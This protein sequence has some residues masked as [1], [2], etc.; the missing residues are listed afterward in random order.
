MLQRLGEQYSEKQGGWSL[1]LSAALHP[2]VA[3]PDSESQ[4]ALPDHTAL[5][6]ATHVQPR[7][8]QGLQSS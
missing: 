1:M 4:L 3:D 5:Y 6:A 7:R 8:V 2:V